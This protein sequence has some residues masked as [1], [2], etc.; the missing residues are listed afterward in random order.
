MVGRRGRRG[1]RRTRLP[2]DALV[3]EL[4]ESAFA[5]D[6]VHDVLLR[7]RELGVRL[8]I[9]DVGTGYSVAT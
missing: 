2:A 9:H 6:G 4:T 5:D 8:A 3:L 7:R 1:A